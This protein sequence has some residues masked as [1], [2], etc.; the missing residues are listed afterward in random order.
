MSKMGDMSK[1]VIQIMMVEAFYHLQNIELR[2]K[3]LRMR[4]GVSFCLPRCVGKECYYLIKCTSN[5]KSS[6]SRHYIL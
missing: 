2:G 5:T 4:F 3:D 1:Y 6:V